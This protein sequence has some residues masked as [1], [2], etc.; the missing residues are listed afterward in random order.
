MVV[1][2]AQSSGCESLLEGAEVLTDQG[3]TIVLCLINYDLEDAGQQGRAIRQ[4]LHDILEGLGARPLL[5][6]LWIVRVEPTDSVSRKLL[7]TIRKRID[8]IDQSYL[9]GICLLVSV[10]PSFEDLAF[11]RLSKRLL[12]ELLPL[13]VTRA[14]VEAH[15]G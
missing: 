7:E 8:H 15:D 14:L 4:S 5:K 11:Y 10:C 3:D 1:K 9:R 2:K 6:S 12:T 13:N